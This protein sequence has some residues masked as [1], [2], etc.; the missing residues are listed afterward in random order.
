ML[1]YAAFLRGIGPGNPDMR[2]E[3]LKWCFEKLGF[4]D[5]KVVISS[6]NVVF[7]SRSTDIS[8]LES[9]IE[10]GL[11]KYLGFNSMTIVL[12][13]KE[14]EKLIKQNPFKELTHGTHSYLL[15]TFFKNKPAKKLK[16]DRAVCNVFNLSGN[17][18]PEVM[19]QLEKDYGK[20]IT[21]RTWK[22]INRIVEKFKSK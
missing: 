18:G 5:V 3:R 2:Q 1:K 17:N 11:P 21:S 16:Y 10:K 9:K 19:T 13:Q 6:G 12:S 4:S 8:A 14:L 20:Q 7:G 15:V 22:T